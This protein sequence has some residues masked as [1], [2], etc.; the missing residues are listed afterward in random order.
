M[1]KSSLRKNGF[2]S[3]LSLLVVLAVLGC[4]TMV[5]NAVAPATNIA[6]TNS[7]GRTISHIYLSPPN[8]DN[9]GPDQLND[10]AIASGTSITITSAACEGSVKVIAE[11]QDGCFISTVIQCS[12][13]AGWTITSD[14]PRNCGN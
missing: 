9:W 10:N 6:I 14:A 7:S 4:G 12:E 8:S 11:D 1:T 2:I 13:N 3:L 5:S